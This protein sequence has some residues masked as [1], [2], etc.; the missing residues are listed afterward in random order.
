MT[1]LTYT[2]AACA[3]YDC[4]RRALGMSALEGWGIAALVACTIGPGLYLGG[5]L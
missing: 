4:A 5:Y 1:P 2:I 3:A